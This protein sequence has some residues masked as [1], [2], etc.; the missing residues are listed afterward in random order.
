MSDDS[1]TSLSDDVFVIN[2]GQFFEDLYD[3]L[4]Y[5]NGESYI[6]NLSIDNLTLDALNNVST[7]DIYSVNGEKVYEYATQPIDIEN[8][9]HDEGEEIEYYC[10]IISLIYSRH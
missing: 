7:S 4:P 5:K 6:V 2:E 9:F 3:T 8:F 1:N 10:S